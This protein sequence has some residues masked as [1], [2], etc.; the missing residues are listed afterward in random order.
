MKLSFHNLVTLTLLYSTD[1]VAELFCDRSMWGVPDYRDCFSLL[2]ELASL[3]DH[4]PRIFTEEQ[5][6][7]DKTGSWPGLWGGLYGEVEIERA[8]QL[9]RI[10]SKG[11]GIAAN[12]FNTLFAHDMLKGSCNFMLASYPDPAIIADAV[13]LVTNLAYIRQAGQYMTERCLKDPFHQ[14]GG[15]FTIANSMQFPFIW[16]VRIRF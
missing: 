2:L 6:N 4:T 1:V 15:A 3:E 5:L 7:L 12:G 11:E 10:Y 13:R 14:G 16:T 8:V 9:P